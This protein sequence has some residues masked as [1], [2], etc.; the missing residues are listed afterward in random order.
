MIKRR[1]VLNNA[2]SRS[3]ENYATVKK[4]GVEVKRGIPTVKRK[5]DDGKV[6]DVKKDSV[7]VSIGSTLNM[8]DFQSLKVEVWHSSFVEQNESVEE[9]FNRVTNIVTDT[10]QKIVND[11]K[12]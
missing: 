7:G 12:E 1:K 5:H 4:N 6:L 3:V 11:F 8:G 2:V 10:L 9:A